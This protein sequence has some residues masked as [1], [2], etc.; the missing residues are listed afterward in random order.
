[1]SAST[2]PQSNT[3]ARDDAP[4]TDW[5][6]IAAEDA[7]ARLGTPLVSGLAESEARK[8]LDQYGP[9][10]VAD[11][12]GRSAW[13]L[14]LAQFTGV[15][16]L[17]LFAAAVLSVFLGDLLDAGAI[18]AIVVLNAALGF[19]QEHRA[20]Q[21]MAALKRMA[22]PLVRVRRDGQVLEIP[23]RALVPG[24]VVLLETGNVV[25]A[26]ARLL[27]SSTLRVQ[28]A[29]LTGESEA[30]EK[31]ASMVFATTRALGDRRNM[32]YS[33]T[34]V[35]YGHGEGIVTATGMATELGKIAGLLQSVTA[36]ADA[37]A[38]AP[39]PARSAAGRGRAGA[40]RGGLRARRDE[41]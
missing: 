12:G 36:G 5:Y 31:D 21:S 10:E 18:L 7:A 11:R 28:E 33:G 22:A 34:V 25:P 24:D 38:E 14:L 23:A 27:R 35:S 30:V 32:V 29:A 39:G 41:G 37:T 1:M 3:E 2:E 6:R 40:R 16:T 19:F 4:V 15:L 20:E 8:R 9:N 17:V 13:R 26:D